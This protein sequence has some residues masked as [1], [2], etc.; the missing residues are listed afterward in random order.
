MVATA[1]RVRRVRGLYITHQNTIVSAALP[2]MDGIEFGP[3][4]VSDR[5][6]I[7]VVSS[8]VRRHKESLWWG[9]W[10]WPGAWCLMMP[11]RRQR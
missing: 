9:G 4:R 6:G 5:R 3:A 10:L 7:R 8:R 2:G 1:A 11:E